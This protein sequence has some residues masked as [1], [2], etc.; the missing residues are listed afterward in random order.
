MNLEGIA[1]GT[2]L[3]TVSGDIVELIEAGADG[4]TARVRYVEVE[5]AGAATANSETSISVDDLI[6]VEGVRFV[7]PPRTSSTSR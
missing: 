1:P 2:R 6:T 7:G 3:V 4:N 5:S